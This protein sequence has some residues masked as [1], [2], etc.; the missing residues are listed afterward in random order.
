M[1]VTIFVAVWTLPGLVARWNRPAGAAMALPLTW[2]LLWV[3]STR[4]PFSW[5]F[6]L[7]LALVYLV[8][9]TRMVR[10][11]NEFMLDTAEKL[12]EREGYGSA[13]LITGKAH[14]S[15]LTTGAVGRTLA[16]TRAYRPRWLRHGGDVTESPEPAEDDSNSAAV[17][18]RPQTTEI[19][20][21][22]RVVAAIVDGAFVVTL[23]MAN[24]ALLT[25][26][27][28][29]EI[30]FFV[31]FLVTPLLFHFALETLA[32][33]TPGKRLLGVTVVTKDGSAPS[34]R[35]R[36]SKSAPTG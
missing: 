35:A 17:R 21:L 12:A 36:T 30:A 8:V 2:G 5:L 31:G 3:V 32:G 20:I 6:A 29:T 22:R 7:T 23:A 27:V 18:P 11:R 4:A 24:G 9:A 10:T 13:C 14:L 15:G 1:T 26:V 25:D 33:S 19:P 28:S 16:V 34:K